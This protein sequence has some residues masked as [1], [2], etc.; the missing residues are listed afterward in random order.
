MQVVSKAGEVA[1]R[2]KVEGR[3]NECMFLVFVAVIMV[4]ERRR[5]VRKL[6]R[7]G[8]LSVGGGELWR[9]GRLLEDPQLPLEYCVLGITAR[10]GPRSQCS[11]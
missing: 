4:G 10:H 1:A 3:K 6:E 5:K 11:Q 8:K 2:L 9:R 7:V